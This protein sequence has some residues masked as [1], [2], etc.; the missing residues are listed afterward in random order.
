MRR[1]SPPGDLGS[2]IIIY[3][4]CNPFTQLPLM[5]PL[6]SHL[7]VDYSPSLGHLP[8]L[9]VSSSPLKPRSEADHRRIGRGSMKAR[10][11]LC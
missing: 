5:K 11:D 10:G 4:N 9:A 6:L 8:H 1:A 7:W 2:E 3:I